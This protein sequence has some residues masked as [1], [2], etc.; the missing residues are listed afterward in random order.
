M[1]FFFDR[2]ISKYIAQM[3]DA[4]SRGDRGGH[5]AKG[6]DDDPRF[7][8]TTG[9]VEWLA[10]LGRDDPPWIVICGDAAIL[11]NEVERAALD[12]ANLTFFCFDKSWMK[13][14][15]EDQ[16]WKL[17]KAWPSIVAKAQSV[18]N[19][20]TIFKVRWGKSIEIE[21]LGRTRRPGR[22]RG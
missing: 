18:A 14:R 10:A 6:L 11:D 16:A 1:R 9:D 12:E 15:F 13:M 19:R 17:V 5:E 2:N 4:F 7:T 22:R 3:L 20:P 8:K 21:E